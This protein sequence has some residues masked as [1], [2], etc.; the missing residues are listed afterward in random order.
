MSFNSLQTGKHIQRLRQQSFSCSCSCFNSLQTGKHI[1]R[2][3]AP[4]VPQEKQGTGFN[5]L[6]TGK[7]IQRKL[8]EESEADERRSLFQFPSNGKAYPKPH[9]LHEYTQVHGQSF[10]SL[11]TGKHIQREDAEWHPW[12]TQTFQFPSNGKAYPKRIR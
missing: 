8:S 3:S 4:Q 2:S 5:S 11:Q 10:N 9:V 12:E 1:Q 7:H 6:Q